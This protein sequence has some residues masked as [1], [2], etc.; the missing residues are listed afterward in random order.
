MFGRR[1]GVGRMIDGLAKTK[2][3]FCAPCAYVL[4]FDLSAAVVRG[5]V[6][7]LHVRDCP[8]SDRDPQVPVTQSKMPPL[9]NPNSRRDS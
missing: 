3:V 8:R 5:S 2:G 9:V 1:R 6:A 4:N 7:I